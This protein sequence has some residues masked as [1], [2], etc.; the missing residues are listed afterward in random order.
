MFNKQTIMGKITGL[1]GWL[2]NEP[3]QFV[4][5]HTPDELYEEIHRLKESLAKAPTRPSRAL[6][7]AEPL[8]EHQKIMDLAG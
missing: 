1:M 8:A 7:S 3:Q 5:S 2:S 4:P 6:R